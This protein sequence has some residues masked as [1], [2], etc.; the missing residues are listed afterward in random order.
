MQ[1][2]PEQPETEETEK[3][4]REAEIHPSSDARPMFWVFTGRVV[5]HDYDYRRRTIPLSSSTFSFR[6]QKL[7]LRQTLY[8]A[9]ARIP[10]PI[11]RIARVIFGTSKKGVNSA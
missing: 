9:R 3:R 6:S 1:Y 11:K 2:D 8:V 7:D 4:Y 10:E 5:H